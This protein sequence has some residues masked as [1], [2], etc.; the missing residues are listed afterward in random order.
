MQTTPFAVAVQ[1]VYATPPPRVA[2]IIEV[3]WGPH[4]YHRPYRR[5]YW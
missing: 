1:P 4:Y 2:I 3:G 5:Y